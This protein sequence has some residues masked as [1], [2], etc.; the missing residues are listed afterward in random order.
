[1]APISKTLSHPRNFLLLRKDVAK[2]FMRGY[3]DSRFSVNEIV[4]RWVMRSRAT[5]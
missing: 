1:M 2:A 5:H 3:R 4:A